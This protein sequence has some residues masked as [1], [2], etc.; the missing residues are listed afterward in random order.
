MWR[1]F[2]WDLNKAEINLKKHGIAF[3]YATT[4][5]DD[6][7]SRTIRDP[8]HSYDE[9]R[10]VTMGESSSSELLVVCHCDRE[11]RVRIISARRAERY[12]R[13]NHQAQGG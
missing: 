2:E 10:F 1:G 13:R 5:F 7:L 4:I 12:E 6:Y 9:E 3:E 8:E 11:E